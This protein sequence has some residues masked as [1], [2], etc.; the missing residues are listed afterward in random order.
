MAPG[1]PAAFS[2]ARDGLGAEEGG[3]G[4]EVHHRVPLLRRRLERRAGPRRA[5]VVDESLKR[6]AR[7]AERGEAVAVADVER[8][9]LRRVAARPYRRRG[10]LDLRGAARHQHDMRSGLGQRRRRR[11]PDPAPGAGDQRA[12]S[13]EPEGRGGGQV[14]HGAS[15]GHERLR[16]SGRPVLTGCGACDDAP[17]PPDHLRAMIS[18]GRM[19]ARLG[20]CVPSSTRAK[21]A[22]TIASLFWRTMWTGKR[23]SAPNGSKS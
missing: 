3:A 14:D 7:G 21:A 6:P 2:P 10:R 12:S 22:E 16:R 18:S 4:V 1:R 23:S 17:Q 13:V 19:S 9:G 11:E 20:A 8:G 15:A 5:R